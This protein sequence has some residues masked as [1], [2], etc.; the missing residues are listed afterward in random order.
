MIKLAA[1]WMAFTLT[2]MMGVDASAQSAA[3]QQPLSGKAAFDVAS[4][5]ESKPN[6]AS[7]MNFPLS[8][9][10]RYTP[11]GG[12]FLTTNLPLIVYI[13]FA[14][15]IEESYEMRALQAQLPPWA[16]STGYDI[17]AR[18]ENLN[19]TKDQM[20][21]MMRTLL[22]DRFQ[23]TTHYETKELPVFALVPVR[24]GKTG[25]KLRQHAKDGLSCPAT[26]P[27]TQPAATM[28]GGFFP[29]VCGGVVGMH[30]SVEGRLNVGARNVT[31]GAIASSLNGMAILGRPVLDQT[32]LTGTYDFALE[33]TPEMPNGVGPGETPPDASGPTFLNALQEQLGLKLRSQKGPVQ[34]IVVD[35][36]EHPSQN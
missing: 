11:N 28:D 25:P 14:Y 29:V 36:V 33:F 30:P 6:A 34:L 12:L 18:T 27:N 32:G 8:G 17:R 9:G 35:H 19:P 23:L 21:Q 20:R 16:I 24:A 4:V 5:R 3:V 13:L 2:V 1:R 26:D 31:M 15:K 10:D 22:S 7:S